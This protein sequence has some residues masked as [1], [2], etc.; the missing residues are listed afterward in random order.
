MAVIEMRNG[1]LSASNGRKKK[2]GKKRNPSTTATTTPAKRSNSITPAKAK[3]FAKANGLKLVSKTVANGKKKR[4]KSRNG[5]AN[6][7]RITKS[8]G[9]FGDTKSDVKNVLALG[10]GAIATNVAGNTLAT[11]FSSYLASFGLGQY[12]PTLF[13]FAVAVFGVPWIAGALAGK[14]AAKMARLGGVLAAALEG[15]STAFPQFNNVNPF[16]T[17][18]I[19]VNPQGQ[20]LLTPAATATI[21]TAA[22]KEAATTA[23]NVTAA[24]LAGFASQMDGSNGG[25]IDT[26]AYMTQ[27]GSGGLVQ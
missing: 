10:G 27:G 17:S 20:A 19:V 25:W 14:D 24:K 23:A 4:K 5:I 13:Q 1:I 16:N 6:S 15:I 22:A 12:A 3:A 9:I 21:A 7:P 11:L 26:D 2:R 18:A 8:N